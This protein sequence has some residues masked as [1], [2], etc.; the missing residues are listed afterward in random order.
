MHPVFV[1]DVL[2]SFLPG[3]AGFVV[4]WVGAIAVCTDVV[5]TVVGGFLPS[6]YTVGH[7]ARHTVLVVIL[8][9]VGMGVAFPALGAARGVVGTLLGERPA[10]GALV[11]VDLDLELG[12]GIHLVH[13]H[14]ALTR[15]RLAWEPSRSIM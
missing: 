12:G 11:E 13:I 14:I 10:V 5:R 7:L 9:S 1:P 3:V 15:R 6:L 4:R 2:D 8:L